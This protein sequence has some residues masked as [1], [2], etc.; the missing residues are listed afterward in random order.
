VPLTRGD[1]ESC[2]TALFAMGESRAEHP[3]LRKRHD[4]ILHGGLILLCIMEYLGVNA[5]MP[6][7]RDGMEGFAMHILQRA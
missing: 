1:V 2:L 4:I 5:L 6:S 7:Q 3:L